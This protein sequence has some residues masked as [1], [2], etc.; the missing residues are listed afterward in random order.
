MLINKTKIKFEENIQTIKVNIYNYDTEPPYFYIRNNLSTKNYR[1]SISFKYL[2]DKF[3]LNI[4]VIRDFSK[5]KLSESKLNLFLSLFKPFQKIIIND[6]EISIK[7]LYFSGYTEHT[8]I[9]LISKKYKNTYST[10]LA[11]FSTEYYNINN[12]LESKI[13]KRILNG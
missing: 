3:G 11:Y 10:T 12:F 8:N 1:I 6:M 7:K 5:F 2:N 4:G 13:F 9:F